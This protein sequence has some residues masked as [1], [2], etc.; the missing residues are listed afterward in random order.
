MCQKMLPSVKNVHDQGSY[1]AENNI[2][3]HGCHILAGFCLEFDTLLLRWVFFVIYWLIK[4]R[5]A[6][7]C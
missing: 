1:S 4:F 2:N 7:I 3:H 5:F 6:H